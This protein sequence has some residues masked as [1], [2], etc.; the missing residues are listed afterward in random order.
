MKDV[1]KRISVLVLVSI[2]SGL[3][4]SQVY[5]Y[6]NP[7]IVE[8]QKD[9]IEKAIFNLIPL[10]VNYEFKKIGN[11]DI[12]FCYKKNQDL[13]GY[14]FKAQG[15]GYQGQI[16]F[17][18]GLNKDLKKLKGIE[19]LKHSETP[20]LGA[21][22]VTD[23]FRKQFENLKIYPT[24]EYAKSSDSLK[25]NQIQAITGATVTSKSI[26]NILNTKLKDVVSVLKNYR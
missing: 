6:A 9:A 16:T 17:M 10:T 5:N 3:V 20:G 18:V 12:Y 24:I 8:N 22:I 26:V 11:Q 19:I 21:K 23:G 14:V 4:L 15:M 25:E 1:I 13:A 7:N 2:F